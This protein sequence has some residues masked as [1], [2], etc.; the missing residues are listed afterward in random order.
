M[1]L[2]DNNTDDLKVLNVSKLQ[3]T[4]TR[5]RHILKHNAFLDCCV[6]GSSAHRQPH[7]Y[8]SQLEREMKSYCLSQKKTPPLGNMHCV[9]QNLVVMV[10]RL[11]NIAGQKISL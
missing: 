11:Q 1:L 5:L 2:H 7:I 10:A 8:K 4:H 9:D 3:S 6:L